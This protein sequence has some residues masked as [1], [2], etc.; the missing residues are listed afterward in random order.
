[1]VD[2]ITAAY[3]STV[4]KPTDPTKDDHIFDGW[5]SDESLTTPYVFSTMPSGGTT[6]YAKWK[7][8]S[9]TITF[10]TAG[11]TSVEAME[12]APNETIETLP[13]SFREQYLFRGWSLYDINIQLP[14]IYNFNQD[15]TLI[16]VWEGI[17]EIYSYEIIEDYVKI[18]GYN[19]NADSLILPDRINNL[20]VK[21]I[22][23]EAFRNNTALESVI[24]G[25]FVTT[26]GN[27]AFNGCQMLESISIPYSVISIGA[28]AFAGC[29]LEN[30][31]PVN[32]KN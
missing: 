32:Y 18:T 19:G 10:D 28:A 25:N 30:P 29:A 21:E 1:M 20:P 27:G 5:F 8:N 24:V 11:G 17:E 9:F 7:V 6:L 16:A 13:T 26:I 22:G 14:L 2:A 23:A 15:I 3:G 4:T 31:Y 12:V